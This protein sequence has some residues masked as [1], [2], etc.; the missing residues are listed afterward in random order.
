MYGKIFSSTF[1]GSMFGAGAEVFAVWGYIIANT[2]GSRVELNARMLAAS[3]GTTP[4]KI[5]DAIEF[6]CKPDPE[7]RNPDH[8]GRRLVREGQYQFLVVSHEIYRGLKDEEERRDYN[9]NRK[10]KS[11]TNNKLNKSH[12]DVTDSHTGSHSVNTS[13]SAS[14]SASAYTGECLIGTTAKGFEIPG[15]PEWG[16]TA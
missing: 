12:R 5:E 15:E 4:Q 8:E 1:T 9:A 16:A 7:S 13:N 3:I 2:I 14:A 10:R 11:R 6:L